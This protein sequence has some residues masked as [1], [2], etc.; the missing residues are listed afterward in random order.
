MLICINLIFNNS[1]FF[2]LENNQNIAKAPPNVIVRSGTAG[3]VIKVN[4]K[5]RNKKR[6]KF[7]I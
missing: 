1:N 2:S 6:K 3:P 5:K 7:L 4:G